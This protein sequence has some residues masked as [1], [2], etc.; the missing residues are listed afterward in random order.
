M[1]FPIK[2]GHFQYSIA[3]LVYQRVDPHGSAANKVLRPP[4]RP[5]RGRASPRRTGLPRWMA[6][7][8]HRH[9][10]PTPWR[11]TMAKPWENHGK[12]RQNHKKH[13]K[14]QEKLVIYPATMFFFAEGFPSGY[15]KIAKMADWVD[16]PK[17]K[18]V[19]TSSSLC[20]RLPE[21]W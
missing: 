4:A 11:K 7:R 3:M 6:G 9:P 18:M 20:R 19:G 21:M 13:Q 5:W 2:N 17:L 15:V 12:M 8:Q 14:K 10:A 1:D 16:L